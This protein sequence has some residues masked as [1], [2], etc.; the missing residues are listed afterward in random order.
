MKQNAIQN[1]RQNHV[2]CITKSCQENKCRLQLDG[3]SPTS[4]A[5]IHGAKYQ[6]SNSFTEKLCDRIVFCGEHGLIMAAVELKGGKNVNISDAREQIQNGLR[7]AES[8]LGVHPVTEWFPLLLYNG[9]MHPDETRL[10]RAK[11][12]EF[13][14]ERKNIDKRNCGTRLSTVLSN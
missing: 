10:L 6:K 5:I 2:S 14:G 1:I 9:G 13:R 12:V 3:V 4:L 11:S 7:I 8:I